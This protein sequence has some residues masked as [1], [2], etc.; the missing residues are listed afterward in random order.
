MTRTSSEEL[1][2][3]SRVYAQG[4]NAARNSSLHTGLAAVKATTNPYTSEPQR[5]RWDEGYAAA[6]ESYRTGL[7]FGSGQTSRGPGV[8]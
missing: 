4:W 3:Q 1:F 6:L 8:K 7:K 5:S 2:Q